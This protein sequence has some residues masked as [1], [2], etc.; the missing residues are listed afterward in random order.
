MTSPYILSSLTG[1]I[2]FILWVPV[3]KPVIDHLW[4]GGKTWCQRVTRCWI[5]ENRF[6][7]DAVTI[8]SVYAGTRSK[9]RISVLR[10]SIDEESLKS[11][12]LSIFD[13]GADGYFSMSHNN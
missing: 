9:V 12:S 3:F 13:F 8:Y 10:I 6:F 2:L 1:R 4:Y 5:P 7:S 11:Q